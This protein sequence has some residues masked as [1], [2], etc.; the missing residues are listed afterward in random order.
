MKNLLINGYLW[1][2]ILAVVIFILLIYLIWRFRLFFGKKRK[3]QDL[4]LPEYIK[5]KWF[6]ASDHYQLA[7]L[8]TITADTKTIILAVH[9]IYGKKEDFQSLVNNKQLQTGTAVITFDQ[10]ILVTK[11][12][13]KIQDLGMLIK[14]INDALLALSNK[15]EDK[16][17]V[18][19]LEGYCCFLGQT[20]LKKNKFIK[21]L[22]LLNPV[23]N[24]KVI[25]FSLASKIALVWGF[26][27]NSRLTI[28]VKIDYKVFTNNEEFLTA[29]AKEPNRYYL[30]QILRFHRKNVYLAKEFNAL[31][32]PTLLITNT[33]NR[34][35]QAKEL[36]KVKNPNVEVFLTKEEYQYL[37]ANNNGKNNQQAIM[38]K[39]GE[40]LK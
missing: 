12:G 28:N 14:D 1:A 33:N 19:L 29:R 10:R 20:I 3:E 11:D 4:Q 8:G 27:F 16:K 23:T 22:I 32:I 24:K 36:M 39:M 17:I 6:I 26:F 30:N 38:E 7:T 25:K 2:I 37:F 40:Y 9:D 5:D 31:Q 15:Y 18:L 13:I 21:G 35:Y 34:F